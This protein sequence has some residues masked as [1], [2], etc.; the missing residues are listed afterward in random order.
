MYWPKIFWLIFLGQ[1]E[2]AFPQHVFLVLYDTQRR[3]LS[4]LLTGDPEGKASSQDLQAHLL[5]NSLKDFQH[6]EA[7]VN[8]PHTYK[9]DILYILLVMMRK[10]W[11]AEISAK[12]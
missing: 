9:N 2:S 11:D 8:H 12:L 5:Q 1:E 3:D 4:R 10:V 6:T 7:L